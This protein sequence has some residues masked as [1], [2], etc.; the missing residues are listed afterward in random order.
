MATGVTPADT[1][2]LRPRVKSRAH[3]RARHPPR[4]TTPVPSIRGHF[5]PAGMPALQRRW[6][7]GRGGKV[8]QEAGRT[9]GAARRRGRHQERGRK[10]KNQGSN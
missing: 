4:A 3:A 9:A 10:K 6:R 7:G 2:F 8:E 1:A 5:M